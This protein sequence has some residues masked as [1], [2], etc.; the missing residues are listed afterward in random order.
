VHRFGDDG[1]A[2]YRAKTAAQPRHSDLHIAPV[3]AAARSVVVVICVL[4]RHRPPADVAT[5]EATVKVNH[6]K[7]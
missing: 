3:C 7:K 1:S 2:R 5:T 4:A 6:I